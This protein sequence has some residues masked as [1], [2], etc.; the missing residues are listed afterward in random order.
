MASANVT[1]EQ[2][3]V[4]VVDGLGNPAEVL[5][6]LETIGRL[7]HDSGTA[8]SYETSDRFVRMLVKLGHES[9]LEHH[10]VT[11][12][13]TCDRATSHQWVRH[14]LASYTQESQRFVEATTSSTS[15]TPSSFAIIDPEFEPSLSADLAFK[16]LL[17]AAENARIN[18]M[19]LRAIGIPKEDARS[20]LLNASRTRFYTTANLRQWRH[21]FEVR[22]AKSAQ[23]NIRS[24]ALNS[25]EKMYVALPA[26]FYD[27]AD[28]YI[29]KN[30]D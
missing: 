11:A 27:L 17:T 7:C 18:Y 16:T 19:A 13:V 25:L 28:K 9:V 14:R 6:K 3:N 15:S 29:K 26:V 2:A 21:F 24:L 1:I 12:F 20:V 5:A 4:S 22:C 10:S 23:H 30:D 8:Q